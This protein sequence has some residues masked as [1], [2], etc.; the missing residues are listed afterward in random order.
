MRAFVDIWN[1]PGKEAK[2]SSMVAESTP[3][4]C[5]RKIP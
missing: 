3:A 4:K 5:A 2:V 1:Q